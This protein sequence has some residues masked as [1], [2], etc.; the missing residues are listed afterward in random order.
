LSLIYTCRHLLAWLSEGGS[1]LRNVHRLVHLGRWVIQAHLCHALL[2]HELHALL[3]VGSAFVAELVAT[4]SH[5]EVVWGNLQTSFN[6]FL[7]HIVHLVQADVDM[8]EL[9]VNQQEPVSHLSAVLV[10]SNL[11]LER[12][13]Q[14]HDLLRLLTGLEFLVLFENGIALLQLEL[15]GGHILS[16]EWL[17]P[18]A[19]KQRL[20]ISRREIVLGETHIFKIAVLLKDLFETSAYS[21]AGKI[22]MA[23]VDHFKRF[24]LLGAGLRT[25]VLSDL[26]KVVIIQA[27]VTE[28]KYLQAL[29]ISNDLSE[30]ADGSFIG[31][32]P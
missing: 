22:I 10:L 14:W 13:Q 15:V 31:G 12:V 16:R 17:P 28:E 30:G 3:D 18:K 32:L 25:E 6:F 5:A 23:Q 4:Q 2:V 7:R 1:A 9:G 19:L 24:V 11:A 26:G 8:F 21:C 29:G 27:R 20:D